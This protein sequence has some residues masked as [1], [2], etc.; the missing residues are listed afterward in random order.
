MK[1]WQLSSAVLALVLPLSALAAETSVW[2]LAGDTSGLWRTDGLTTV[3]ASAE[4]IYIQTNQQ[5]IIFRASDVDH[6]VDTVTITVA[7]PNDIEANF[8]WRPVKG[9][10]DDVWRMPFLIPKSPS[11]SEVSFNP[12]HYKAWNPTSE[13][14]GFEFPAGTELVLSD[15]RLTRWNAWEKAVEIFKSYWTFDQFRPYS[16]NFLWGPLIVSNPIAR[17]QLFDTLPPRARSAVWFFYG[18]AII[19]IL[20]ALWLRR[21]TH[22]TEKALAVLACGIAALWLLFDLR[23]G[24]EILSYAKTD[25]T[26]HV[27]AK[28]GEKMLRTH[29]RFYEIAER[30]LPELRKQEMYALIVPDDSPFYANLRYMSYPSLPLR[31]PEGLSGATLWFV[32]ERPD[33]AVD[34]EGKLFR[35]AGTVLLDAEGKIVDSTRIPLTNPGKLLWKESEGTFLFSLE[36]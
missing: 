14:F 24:L 17:A 8:L 36:P 15:V 26:T 7:T 11:L 30:A 33:V 19:L 23:M 29:E 32:I 22:D 12:S 2:E 13:L 27:F 34:D 4:G 3:R 21:R 6:P 18:A 31:G 1:L 5:G 9:A 20:A 25:L 16:I 28:K 35:H 10:S